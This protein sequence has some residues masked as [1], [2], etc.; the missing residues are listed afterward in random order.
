MIEVTT[1]DG[2]TAWRFSSRASRAF[3]YS[4]SAFLT[5]DGVLIDTGIPASAGEFAAVLDTVPVR[6]VI[7]S[8]HHEDHAGNV[9]LVAARGLPLWIAPATLP[10]LQVVAPI[11]VYRRFTWTSM[12]PLITAVIP[13]DPAPL[14]VIPAPG[15]APDH[16]IVWDPHSRTLFSADLFLGTAVRVAHHDED[17]WQLIDSLEQAAALGPERLFCAHRGLITDAAAA[18]RAKATWLRETIDAITTRLRRGDTDSQILRAVLGGESPTGWASAGEYSR[19]N[20][21]RIVRTR[22]GHL[23]S[24]R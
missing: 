8:H 23:P 5:A 15:H 19:R 18:L 3:G 1:H 9:E 10:L 17:P 24:A 14:A 6:G 2:V 11:G 7:V 12:R 13:F 20:L 21:V 22:L 4:S 16:H